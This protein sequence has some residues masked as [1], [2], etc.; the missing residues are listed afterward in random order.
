MNRKL[1]IATFA[2][3]VSIFSFLHEMTSSSSADP[4]AH[5]PG[6]RTIRSDAGAPIAGLTKTEEAFFLAGK[7][8]FNAPEEVEEGLGPTMNL[9]S[10][11]GCHSQPA[12]GGSSPPVNPQA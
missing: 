3:V 8:E 4:S 7:D 9:D 12:I 2:A 11:G 1:V 5:D 6:V 10:C